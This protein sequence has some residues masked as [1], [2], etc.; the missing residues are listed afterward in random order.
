M[1]IQLFLLLAMA[2]LLE[3]VFLKQCSVLLRQLLHLVH[4]YVGP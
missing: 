1:Y 2:H 4:C 3:I